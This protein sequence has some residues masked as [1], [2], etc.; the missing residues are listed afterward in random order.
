MTIFIC[1]LGVD[2][3][4]VDWN[5]PFLPRIGEHVYI[6]DFIPDIDLT[7]V[8]GDTL[9]VVDIQWIK[10]DGEIC[11]VLFLGDKDS[12]IPDIKSLHLN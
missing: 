5:F 1:V 2:P 7:K 11:P 12:E 4:R 9:K 3:E 6:A 8:S 10:I